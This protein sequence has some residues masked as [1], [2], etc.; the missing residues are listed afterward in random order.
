MRQPQLPGR[1][2]PRPIG[3]PVSRWEDSTGYS[4]V[5]IRIWMV[6]AQPE[7]CLRSPGYLLRIVGGVLAADVGLV[8]EEQLLGRVEILGVPLP[9]AMEFG[10]LFPCHRV[11]RCPDS[12]VA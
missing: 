6:L 5:Q 7:D 4:A 11:G 10:R 8:E 9:L 1:F 3:Q 12:R 2:V